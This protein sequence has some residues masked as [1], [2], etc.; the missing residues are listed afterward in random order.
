[1]TAGMASRPTEEHAL[2][3]FL[4]S[5]ADAPSALLVDGEAGIGKITVWLGGLQRAR[6]RGLRVLSARVRRRLRPPLRAS[7]ANWASDRKPSSGST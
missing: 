7:A 6:D 4:D 3:E 1:M 5:A 2:S